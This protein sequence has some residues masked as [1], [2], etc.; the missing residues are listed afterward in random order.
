MSLV[1]SGPNR[2]NIEQIRAFFEPMPSS[3]TK[4]LFMVSDV[5][6]GA[7]EVGELVSEPD[8][9]SCHGNRYHFVHPAIY[10]C[11]SSVEWALL[12]LDAGSERKRQWKRRRRIGWRKDLMVNAG[13]QS[14]SSDNS[15]F[16]VQLTFCDCE[17]GMFFFISPVWCGHDVGANWAA[18]TW[19]Q[20]LECGLSDSDMSSVNCSHQ[21]QMSAQ[22]IG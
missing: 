8:A 6:L 2:G 9:D 11:G 3:I 13:E 16:S 15:G 14:W 21:L 1:Y 10:D 5:M 18:Q 7:E 12:L 19:P 22:R 17:R 20:R 4:N